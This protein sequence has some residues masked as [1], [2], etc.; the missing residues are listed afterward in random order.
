VYASVFMVLMVL[1]DPDHLDA[2]LAAWS[3]V[4]VRGV[5]VLESTGLHRHQMEHIPMRYT[6]GD[7][8]AE[9]NYTLFAIV[10]TEE[11]V[12]A[13]LQAAERIVGDL[14]GPHTGVL[15]AWPLT[16]VKGV[17]KAPPQEEA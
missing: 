13:C 6:Y 17:P 16:L 14:S 8:A 2:L 10:E 1:D 3:A 15:A 9:G 7:T 11:L 4:G 5:T 12:Q